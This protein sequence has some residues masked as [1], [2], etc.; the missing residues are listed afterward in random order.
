VALFVFL[1]FGMD[2]LVVLATSCECFVGPLTCVIVDD[3]L[4]VVAEDVICV[5]EGVWEV[6]EGEC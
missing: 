2:F 3:S 5:E 1:S 4:Y 6:S